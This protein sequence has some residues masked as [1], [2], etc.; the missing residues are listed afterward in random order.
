MDEAVVHVVD[1]DP[2]LRNA[3]ARL[4]RSYDFSTQTYE[5]ALD[6]LNRLPEPGPGCLILDLS[7]PNMSGLQLQETLQASRRNLVAIFVSG[8][9]DIPA[10][11]KAMKAGAGEFL[12]KPF[13]E[14][15][16]IE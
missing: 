10:S 11:V 4:L 6:F 14:M 2:Q 7:M 3:M 1:D 9:G 8:K 5:S 12:T 13:E 15:T 16:L